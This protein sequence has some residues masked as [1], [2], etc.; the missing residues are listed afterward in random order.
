MARLKRI[1]DRLHSAESI[2]DMAYP[3]SHLHL[4]EPKRAG[5][6]SVRV[7]GNWRVT[8]TFINGEA[9]DVDYLDYH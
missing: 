9:R 1:L 5:V 8:F 2:R 4:L 6:W 3:G 7:S